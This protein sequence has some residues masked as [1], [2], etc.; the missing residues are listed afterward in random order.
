MARPPPNLIVVVLDCVR[1]KSLRVC[2]SEAPA[3]T[4]ELDRLASRGVTYTHAVAPANWTV[5]SHWSMLTGQYPAVHRLRLAGRVA[6]APDTVSIELSHGGYETALFSEQEFLVAGLGF[7]DGYAVKVGPAGGAGAVTEEKAPPRSGLPDTQRLYS[8]TML[9]VL[10]A[11]PPLIVPFAAVDY[12]VQ[13]AYKTRI[14]SDEIAARF[15]SWIGARKSSRPFHALVN[16]VDAH[17]PYLPSEDERRLG[18][19]SKWYARTPRNFLLLLPQV[20]SRTPWDSVRREYHRAIASADRKLGLL[21]RALSEAGAL[22]N[23][24][25]IITADHGQALGEAGTVYHGNGATDALTRVPLVVVPPGNQSAP[26][27]VD[28]WTTLCEI[29]RW[30]RSYAQLGNSVGTRPESEGAPDSDGLPAGVVYCEGSPASDFGRQLRGRSLQEGWNR[31]C[32]VAYKDRDKW[33]LDLELGS[34]T[35]W[36][37]DDWTSDARP[38]DRLEGPASAEVFSSIFQPYE[39]LETRHAASAQRLV[40]VHGSVAERLR[41]WGY[42]Q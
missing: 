33:V 41:A 18:W 25:L 3:E 6:N 16:F 17:E 30:L 9:N 2:G 10:D 35:H 32:L 37:V 27:R 19:L 5:P 34:I 13:T 26:S 8:D 23:S 29:P 20:R 24:A 38:G 39:Q 7:E 15:Q 31:R 12:R 36:T 21:V 40:P 1:A 14:C 22:E 11:I 28:R 42:D 4:P